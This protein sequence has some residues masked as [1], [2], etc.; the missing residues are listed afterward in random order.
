MHV[1]LIVQEVDEMYFDLVQL[2]PGKINSA[3]AEF[4]YGMEHS[5]TSRVSEFVSRCILFRLQNL[6][7][8]Q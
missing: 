4:A 7:S 8:L 3:L 1:F 2:D 5:K 6:Q